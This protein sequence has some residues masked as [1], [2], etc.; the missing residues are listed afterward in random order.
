MPGI[1]KRAHWVSWRE[2]LPNRATAGQ[3]AT[4]LEDGSGSMERMLD[5]LNNLDADDSGSVF[6]WDGAPIEF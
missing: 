6:A 1:D 5:V 4:G 2:R 3:S